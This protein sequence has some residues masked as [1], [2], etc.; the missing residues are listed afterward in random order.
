MTS[1]EKGDGVQTNKLWNECFT[2][3]DN[4]ISG[5]CRLT[6]QL[7][8]LPLESQKELDPFYRDKTL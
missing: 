3:F 5:I 8:L 7:P 4:K 6:L 1:K 2:V